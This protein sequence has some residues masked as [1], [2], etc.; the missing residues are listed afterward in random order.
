MLT[1]QLETKRNKRRYVGKKGIESRMATK[2]TI[3]RLGEESGGAGHSLDDD[4]VLA[5]SFALSS[6]SAAG[7]Y[8][9]P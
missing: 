7:L 1:L 4:V 6:Q 9:A 8:I 2:L 3:F 5:L